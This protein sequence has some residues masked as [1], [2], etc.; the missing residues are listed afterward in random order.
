MQQIESVQ[1]WIVCGKE[2]NSTQAVVQAAEDVLGAWIGTINPAMPLGPGQQLKI[3]EMMV[4][5]RKKL[6]Q[7]LMLIDEALDLKEVQEDHDRY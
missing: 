5:D 6:I 2:Y 3:H 4:Q 1:R 7:S